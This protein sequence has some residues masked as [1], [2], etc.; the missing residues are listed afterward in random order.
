MSKK[1]FHMSIDVE[2]TDRAAA[3]K[4]VAEFIAGWGNEDDGFEDN[5]EFKANNDSAVRFRVSEYVTGTEGQQ[6]DPNI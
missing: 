4:A 2:T 3:A 6:E 5:A 1:T